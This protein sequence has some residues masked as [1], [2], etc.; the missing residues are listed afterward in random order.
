MHTGIEFPRLR[1]RDLEGDDAWLPDAFAGDRN[2]V[3]VAFQRRHQ[4]LVDSWVPWLE[5]RAAE[6]PASASTN[7]PRSAGS[8]HRC[9]T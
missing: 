9:A 3:I 5:D 8:G 2:V 4:A 6:I 1:A 7:C